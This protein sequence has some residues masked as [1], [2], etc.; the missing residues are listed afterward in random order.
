VTTT[1]TCLGVLTRDPVGEA[2][3]SD[4]QAF[5]APFVHGLARVSGRRLD[6]LAIKSAEEGRGHCRRFVADARREFDTVVFVEVCN[7]M[8]AAALG[9]WGFR[10]VVEEFAGGERCDCWRWDRGEGRP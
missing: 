3:G 2:V 6:V 8:L 7:E 1:D 9:R 4:F 5:T 10:Q